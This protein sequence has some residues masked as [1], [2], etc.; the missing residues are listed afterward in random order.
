MSSPIEVVY[1]RRG[2]GSPLVLLHGI[3]HRWQ[4]WE[5]V[6]DLLAERHDVIAVDLP[7]FGL[8]PLVAGR[9]YTMPDAVE[10]AAEMFASFGLDR[11][12]VAGNSL[13]GVLSLELASRGLVRSATALA[14]AGFWTPRDRAWALGVL[15]AM[16]ASGRAPERL[17]TLIINGKLTR[18]LS[19]SLLYGRPSRLVAEIVQAD[20][21][22]MVA[23]PAFDIVAR[24]GRSYVYASPAPTVPT[25]VIWGARDRIL[26]PRQARR[27]ALLLPNA[28][29]IML[30]RCGHVPMSD[31][32]DRIADLII[33]TCARAA[34][35]TAA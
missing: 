6:L 34:L 16:R 26:W 22:A 28:Q 32:P 5:P 7:G 31:D 10:I 4:A 11:P 8:S 2:A 13:G 14:P 1:E 30:P 3:G 12:H 24:A 9:A 15:T 25:T 19:A 18:I 33:G 27:A 21:A 35:D 17:R 23:S 20:L 29:H